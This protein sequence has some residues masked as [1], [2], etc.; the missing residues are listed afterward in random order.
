M[1]VA[2]YRCPLGALQKIACRPSLLHVHLSSTKDGGEVG[3]IANNLQQLTRQVVASH[4]RTLASQV[5]RS[6]LLAA[7]TRNLGATQADSEVFCAFDEPI[8]DFNHF[9]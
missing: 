8:G 6:Q 9:H 5:Q 2:A 4:C 1:K 3:K 7:P